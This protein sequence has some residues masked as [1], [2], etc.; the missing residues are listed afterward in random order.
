ML[1]RNSAISVGIDSLRLA[2]EMG[3]GF[4]RRATK[5]GRAVAYY[6]GQCGRGLG[7]LVGAGRDL[8]KRNGRCPRRL[9]NQAFARPRFPN[10]G[11]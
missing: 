8:A 9:V 6:L 2:A 11:R 3:Q 4:D 7:G 5:I 1:A 10:L